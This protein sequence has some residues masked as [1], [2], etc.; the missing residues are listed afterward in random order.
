MPAIIRVCVTFSLLNSTISQDYTQTAR[1]VSYY[2]FSPGRNN[3]FAIKSKTW[4]QWSHS[5]RAVTSSA[6][7]YTTAPVRFKPGALARKH[8]VGAGL[9]IF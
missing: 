5:V 6:E 7:N 4:T 9:R 1:Q 3:A 2:A 8:Y